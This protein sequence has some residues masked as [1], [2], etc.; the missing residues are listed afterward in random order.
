MTSEASAAETGRTGASF[1]WRSYG[2]LIALAVIVLLFTYL[3]DGTFISARNIAQLMRQGALLI[4]VAAGVSILIIQ[5]EIDLSIGSAVYLAGLAAAT[6]QT[7]WGWATV[8][9]I[10]LAL[11]VGIAMGAWQ[12]FWVARFAIPS[13]VVTLSG[14][15]AFRGIGY[16]WSDAATYAPMNRS[17][18][19]LSESFIP[20]VLSAVIIIGLF[21]VFAVAMLVRF[22]R[23]RRRFGAGAVPLSRA[24]KPIVWAGLL[25]AVLL[26]PSLGYRGLPMAVAIALL[27]TGVLGFVTLGTTFG[28][29]LYA[30]GGNREAAYLSGINIPRTIFISFVIMGAIYAIGGVLVTARLNAIAP[31][32]GEFLELEA[33]AAAVIGGVSLGGGIGT[34]YGALTGA[35]LLVAV[36]NGMSLMNVS[37]FTQLVVKGLLLGFAVVFDVVTRPGGRRPY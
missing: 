16:V 29:K 22:S 3:T 27:V 24:L 13:F 31:S 17:Y 12:G 2:M 8:P 14:L 26:Y 35:M 30:I 6:A 10:G 9:A 18:G 11:A 4:V 15:L 33:I 37:S 1:N 36:D 7:Q 21:V 34:V 20:P 5:R 23:Q 28:R 19:A 32:V 25:G